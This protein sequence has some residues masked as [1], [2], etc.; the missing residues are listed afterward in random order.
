M[1]YRVGIDVGGTFT[2]FFVLGPEDARIVHKT[3]STPEDPS[4]AVVTGLE[5]IAARL[6]L[7]PRDFARSV[8]VIVHGTTVTTNAVLTHRGART[9]L[10]VTKGFRDVLA[11]RDGTREA[12]YDNR[13]Q[14]PTPLVP[15]Y[16][17]LGVDER[18]DYKGDEVRPLDE[19]AVRAAAAS[20]AR[21]D[22]EAVAVSFMHAPQNPAHE[23]RALELLREALPDAY[24]TASAELLPQ[25]RYY[26]RT[27]TAVLNAYVGPI[28]AR[29][30][31]GLTRR[32]DDVG[33][34]GVLLVMQSNGGVATPDEVAA[35]AALSL[36]SGPA[37]GPTGGLWQLEPHG[38]RECITIDMGGTSFDAALVKDGEPLVMTDGLVDRW[39]LALPMIDL[40]TIGAG[41]GSIAHVDEGGLLHVGPQSAGAVPGPACYGRGGTAPTTTDA[42][43][44]LGYLDAHSFLHGEMAL[45][46]VRA[47][48][49]IREHVAAPLG[50]GVEEAAAG[51]YDLV[52]VT[53]AAGVREISVRRGLDPRDFPLVVAGG[54]GPLHA[55][56]IAREL[57]IHLLVVPRESSIF[58]AAGMLTSDFKHDFVRPFKTL[59]AD[60]EP[61][62]V[63]GLLDEMAR[64]AAAILRREQVG[65]D[66]TTLR[67]SVDLRYVG[68]WHELSVPLRWQPGATPDL[69][70]LLADF[71]A[72]HDRL[73]GYST[74][75]MPVEALA[76]RLSAVGA[77]ERPLR[78]ALDGGGTADAARTGRRRIWAPA[79]RAMVEADV[80]DGMRLQAGATLSGPAIVELANTT[81]VVHRG[82]ELVVDRF[83]SF[84]LWSGERGLALA[85]SLAPEV[86]LE[87]AAT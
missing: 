22:V 71:H 79:Q 4:L 75:E 54:A 25:V 23:R 50:L 59:V 11:L 81:I 14:P 43:L 85:R 78:Q 74:D 13:L 68:Q 35:R 7:G 72:E 69:E 40:H 30:L 45:D 26:S 34:A 55:A 61:G 38:I 42:D 19:D 62:R 87:P 44:V 64:E 8:E 60:A 9:G 84:V 31:T 52:N 77:T 16:L 46:P 65:P 56:E 73:F 21:H 49:A 36:L 1:S 18:T 3:S 41:G 82:F 28:I 80:V 24:L 48:Q 53:M 6:E 70:R 29:Y 51:I 83:G 2:D 39:R 5:Q 12:P 10:I 32:L 37:S 66:R 15:R 27:S 57:D 86:G 67:P 20:L 17:R 47:E 63:A 76:V 58:C 33:F